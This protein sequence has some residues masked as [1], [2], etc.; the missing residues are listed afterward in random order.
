MARRFKVFTWSDG[1]HAFT[2][3]APSRPR[4]L[5]AWGIERDIFKDGLAREI[6][7]GA[8]HDAAL[9][10]PGQVIQRGEAIDTGKLSKI[11]PRTQTR[12]KTA[13]SRVQLTALK[14]ER[15]A[16]DE[17]HADAVAELDR[18]EAELRKD[19]DAEDGRHR[20]ARD[21]VSLKIRKIGAN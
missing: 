19:R 8:D 3:A 10:A 20:K 11:A 7:E 16:L 18:R 13:K 15:D 4:A 21:A 12:P 1:F 6:T 14:A 9:R 17:A 5:A 2:V